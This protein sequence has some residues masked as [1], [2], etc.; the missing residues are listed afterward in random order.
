MY[1]IMWGICIIICIILKIMYNNFLKIY[2]IIY[3]IC[4]NKIFLLFFWK[5]EGFS[6]FGDYF[7]KII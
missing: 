4:N 3:N 7:W 5:F 2:V 6:F 1:I